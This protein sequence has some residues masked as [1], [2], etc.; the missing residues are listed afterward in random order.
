MFSVRVQSKLAPKRFVSND[1]ALALLQGNGLPA[2]RKQAIAE[3]LHEYTG[4]SVA[5]LVKTNLRIEYGAFQKELLSNDDQTTGTL[6]TRFTGTTLDPLSKVS[7]YDPQS[8]AIGAA[9]LGAFNTYVR[10]ALNYTGDA[11]YKSEIER[12]Q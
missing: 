10:Q 1:Y 6:D 9:Y 12:F 2:E 8:A 5:Y 3:K 4:L 11:P 7:Q